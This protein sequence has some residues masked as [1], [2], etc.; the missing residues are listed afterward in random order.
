MISVGDELK[1]TGCNVYSVIAVDDKFVRLR[2]VWFGEKEDLGDQIFCT[3][4][5]QEIWVAM[6]HARHYERIKLENEDVSAND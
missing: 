4:E 2:C 1:R 3:R 5:G 6:Y